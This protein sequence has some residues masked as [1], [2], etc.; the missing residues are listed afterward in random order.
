MFEPNC[1]VVLA[2]PELAIKSKAV[3]FFMQTRLK[4][5]ILLCLNN[6]QIEYSKVVYIGGRFLIYST[7]IKKVVDALKTCF[8]IHSF[9]L[10]QE[11]KF[12]GLS[13]ICSSAVSISTGAIE[14]GTF[15]IRGKSFVKEF[16]SK[17]LEE[18][19]GGAL[20]SAYPKLKVKL[21]GPEK[22]LFCLVQKTMV[23]FYFSSLP[24]AGGMP[25]GSQGRV[26]L[27]TDSYKK[28]EL[29]HLG[30]LLLKTG[31]SLILVGDKL[32]EL[33]ELEEWNCFQYLKLAYIEKSK[34]YYSHS[35]VRAFFSPAKSLEEAKRDSNLVG[36]KVFVPFLF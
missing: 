27:I 28:E 1:V 29:L 3:R 16:S 4:R 9:F 30:K 6:K 15:A 7:E 36:V 11:K 8:G 5:N 22:E 19:V 2:A 21:K 32:V 23:I 20:L 12:I 10:A 33:K 31:C 24:A 13:D 35:G 18:E 34:S 25:V 26:A 17:K 14:E